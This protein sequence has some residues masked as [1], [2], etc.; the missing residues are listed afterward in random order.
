MEYLR[1]FWAFMKVGALTFGGGYAMLPILQREIVER[2]GWATDAEVIDYY[3]MGQCLPGIIMVNTSVFV[4]TRRKGTLGGVVAALG[5][6]FPSLVIITVIAMCLTAFADAPI[7]KNA[8]AGIRVCVVVLII[9]AVVKLW[10]A[11]IVDWKC[12]LIFLAV[13]ICSVLTDL[14]P[15]IFVIVCALLGVLLTVIGTRKGAEG[16]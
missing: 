11:A 16:K 13:L 14:S 3:A 1:I 2:N 4:G 9:N 10:K 15:V 8:F 6:V 5:A 7:V 12:V